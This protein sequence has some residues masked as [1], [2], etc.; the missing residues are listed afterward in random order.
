[1]EFQPHT[2]SC[3]TRTN[4]VCLRR[5]LPSRVNALGYFRVR[6]TTTISQ[7]PSVEAEVA[8]H[9]PRKLMTFNSCFNF[10]EANLLVPLV[11]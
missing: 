1:M 8:S 3:G 4:V 6:Q 5:V 9:T 11:N 10:S 7:H 2:P